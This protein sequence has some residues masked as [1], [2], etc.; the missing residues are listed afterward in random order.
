MHSTIPSKED[1]TLLSLDHIHDLVYEKRL[2]MSLLLNGT[3][4]WYIANCFDAP[5]T[6]NSYFPQ[7]LEFTL[8]KLAELLTMLAEHGIYR[9]F[10][11]VY[12]WHQPQRNAEAHKFLLKG[13]QALLGFPALV[14]TYRKTRWDVRFYGDMS[15]FPATFAGAL[16]NPPRYISGEPEHI[17]YFGVDG[18]SPH[19]NAFAMAH[20]FSQQHG[21]APTREDMMHLYYGDRDI[22]PLD[23]LVGF[24]R[25]YSR[26]GIPHLLD[27]EE[28]IYVTAV[29]PLVMSELSLRSI[30]HDYLYNRH[31][32]GRDYQDIHP[33][34]IQRLKQ[35]YASN[36]DTVM[37][38]TR[39][40]E[41]LVYPAPAIQWPDHMD[42]PTAEPQIEDYRKT[43]F[44]D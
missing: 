3:R 32:V 5:P 16:Q 39:K 34:E 30:L 2:N 41:D 18:N 23:I 11:P 12:S 33:N 10:I 19:S 40:Y 20:E 37:G 36:R 43:A 8:I 26:M 28:S 6:D 22:R 25:I 31:D 44:G 7:Y 27:G 29:T 13:I 42:N 21:H 15:T 17:V 9:V 4:R 38:L 35:F 14:E 24:S 1:F